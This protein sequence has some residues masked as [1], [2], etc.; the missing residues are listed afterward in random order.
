M[1][2]SDY[3]KLILY[4]AGMASGQLLFKFVVR[5]ISPGQGVMSIVIDPVFVA[6]GVLYLALTFVWIWILTTIPLSRAYPLSFLSILIVSV[7]SK[8]VFD[9]TFNL[10]YL[11][12][13]VFAIFG[14][15]LVAVS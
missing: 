2:A 15:V 3:L 4:S 1:I 14:L 5:R 9:E 13:V 6:A 8:L 11:I 7:G 12:G 10:V